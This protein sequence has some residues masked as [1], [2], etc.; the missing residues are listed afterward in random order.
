MKNESCWPLLE[1]IEEK[2]QARRI[3]SLLDKFRVDDD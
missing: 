1:S 3:N 2:D